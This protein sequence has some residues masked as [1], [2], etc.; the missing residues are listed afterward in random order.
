MRKPHSPTLK[1]VEIRGHAS[2]DGR[3]S[4]T[5]G[6]ARLEGI[7]HMFT[8][9]GRRSYDLLPRSTSQEW[10]E[11]TRH[12][13]YDGEA[14]ERGY[15]KYGKGRSLPQIGD[16]G[17]RSS[18]LKPRWACSTVANWDR[19]RVPGTDAS[20][21]GPRPQNLRRDRSGTTAEER[22]GMHTRSSEE[23]GCGCVRMTASCESWM[24]G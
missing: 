24:E 12:P 14:N 10:H 19:I 11:E 9:L 15:S 2:R 22:W 8:P 21:Q 1:P 5:Q 17:R 4:L 7:V 13:P 3:R 18:A 20:A 23:Q 16:S 6:Y